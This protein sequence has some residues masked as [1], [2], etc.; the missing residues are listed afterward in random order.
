[1]APPIQACSP[2]SGLTAFSPVWRAGRR[3]NGV[4]RCRLQGGAA[5]FAAQ[6]PDGRRRLCSHNHLC[7]SLR[8]VCRGAD[9]CRVKRLNDVKTRSLFIVWLRMSHT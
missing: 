9:L 7:A 6:Q 2:C 5:W 8:V 1:M 4:A 3:R